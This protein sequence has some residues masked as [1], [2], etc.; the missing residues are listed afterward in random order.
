MTHRYHFRFPGE[1]KRQ[2]LVYIF[3]LQGASRNS[4]LKFVS[5]PHMEM[6]GNDITVA[7]QIM[8][9]ANDD[10]LYDDCL[11]YEIVAQHIKSYRDLPISFPPVLDPIT[12]E[13]NSANIVRIRFSLSR[14]L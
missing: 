6:S 1:I 9:T 2:T 13:L 5:L 4:E 12:H 7:K 14:T 10:I 11:A 3:I 8:T